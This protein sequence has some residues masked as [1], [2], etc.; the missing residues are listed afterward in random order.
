MPGGSSE[1]KRHDFRVK[2]F[3]SSSFLKILEVFS[4]SYL[5]VRRNFRRRADAKTQGN[6]FVASELLFLRR[7]GNNF[8]AKYANLA[9]YCDWLS[10]HPQVSATAQTS[11]NSSVNGKKIHSLH[12]YSE[13]LFCEGANIAP[14]SNTSEILLCSITFHALAAPYVHHICL[15]IPIRINPGIRQRWLRL[16]FVVGYSKCARKERIVHP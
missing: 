12:V 1:I 8:S 16:L 2:V 14:P 11:Y 7:C 3:R 6:A 10:L 13:L 9:E 5:F 4:A 15:I